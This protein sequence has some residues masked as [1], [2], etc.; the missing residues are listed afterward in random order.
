MIKKLIIII[1]IL[2]GIITYGKDIKYEYPKESFRTTWVASVENMNFPRIETKNGERRIRNTQEELKNDWL[3]ILDNHERMNFNAVI[4]QVSPTLDALYKSNNRPWSH[5]ISGK[6]GVAPNWSGDFDLVEWMIDETHKRGMEFHAWFNPYRVTHKSNRTMTK[7]ELLNTLSKE[8]FARKNPEVVYL[9][10]GKLYLNPG[11]DKVINHIKDTVKEFLVKYDVDAIHFDDYFYP[12]KSKKD[13]KDLYFGDNYEDKE[14]FK[15]YPRGRKYIDKLDSK[16]KRE[17]YNKEVKKWR[18][19]NIDRM[20]MGV[21]TVIDSYNQENKKS[22]QWGISPFGIWEHKDENEHG[23]KTPVTSTSSRRDIYADTKKWVDNQMI[24]Y[25]IPQIYWEFGL[26]AAPYGVLAKWWSDIAKRSRTQLYIG[27]SSYKHMN[28]S[29]SNS[30]KNIDEI[31]SQIRY[32]QGLKNIKG[33]VLFGYNDIL[34]DKS[35]VDIGTQ[36]RNQHIELLEKKYF[37]E[38]TLVPSKKWLDKKETKEIENI[39]VVMD[40]NKDMS[41]NF[42]DP[43]DSDTRFY[44][45]YISKNSKIDINNPKNILK[46]VGRNKKSNDQGI[47][48]SKEE[49]IGVKTIMITIKDRAGVESKGTI[50][51][52]K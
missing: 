26:E 37:N 15:K 44:V 5:V 4:F 51:K 18:V 14:T 35:K 13:G 8:N 7:M 45:V 20:V 23:S 9:F 21:K 43:V 52:R 50:I 28:A 24:D 1:F 12:Y 32:N 27:H 48:I 39:E 11:D 46:V 34:I 42:L 10:D 49:L 31:P 30:W 33:T 41:L 47:K 17:Q 3:E 2:I 25:I 40:K 19:Q 38:K 6:Q 36:T 22:V 29:R 16:E